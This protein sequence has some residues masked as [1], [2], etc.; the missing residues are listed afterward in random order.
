MRSIITYKF[1][2][3]DQI[4]KEE[5]DKELWKLAKKRAGFKKHLATYIIVN[6]FLWAI[7]YFTEDSYDDDNFPW[8]VWPTIG[9]GMGIAFQYAEAYIYPKSN[10]AEREY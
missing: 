10:S 4:S 6:A 3:M 7:W 1:L 9:W 8:P 5:K 2:I